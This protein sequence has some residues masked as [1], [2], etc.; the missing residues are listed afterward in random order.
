MGFGLH[1]C[2]LTTCAPGAWGI[3]KTVSDVL[4]LE[5]GVVMIYHKDA[6]NQTCSLLESTSSL[7]HQTISVT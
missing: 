5:L 2:L 7:N 4:E 1:A 3:Q 6:G